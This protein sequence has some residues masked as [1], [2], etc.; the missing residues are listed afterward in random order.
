MRKLDKVLLIALLLG[1][2]FCLYGLHWGWVE[3]WNSDQMAFKNLFSKGK[4]PF[5][6]EDFQKPPFHTYFN[7]FLSVIPVKIIDKILNLSPHSVRTTQLLWSRTLTVFLFLGATI[8]VFYITKRFFG[9]FAARFI[10]IIFSTSAGF[11]ADS[12]Y[13]TADVP[14]LFWM[15]LAFYFTQNICLNTTLANYVYAGFFTGIATA[16]KYNALSI[17]IAIVV[18]H[19]LSVKD[20]SYIKMV[21]SKKLFLGLFMVLIGFLVGNPFALLNYSNFISDFRYNYIVTPIYN[22]ESTGVEQ[23]YWKFF[24]CFTEIIGW[25]S[26][27]VF[28]IGFL[29]SIYSLSRDRNKSWEKKG[30]ILLLSV[31]LVYYYKFG[32]FP[33][34]E[35]RFV[36]PILPFWLMLSGPLWNEVKHHKILVTGLLSILLSYNFVCDFYVGKRFAEDPRMEAQEW[37]K[38]NI[39]SNS[40][41]E[42]S[43]FVPSW[44]LLLGV[45]LKEEKMPFVSGRK[46]IYEDIF[47]PNSWV[48]KEASKREAEN[49]ETIEWYSLE[50]LMKRRPNYLAINSKYYGRFFDGQY[51]VHYPFMRKFFADLLNGQY[52]YEIVFDRASQPVPKIIYPQRIEFVDNEITI[53]KNKSI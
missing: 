29:F 47:L 51:A 19:L 53:L 28:M 8:L 40:S 44:N 48:I 18:A 36:M 11:I 13:L 52:P 34:L 46:R 33:R 31:F 20:D 5:Q 3:C 14:V 4:L 9:S 16:T 15:L 24:L 22:G 41:I 23:G 10:V 12:H 7:F 38:R 26:L 50:E 27:L 1:L 45:N 43:R 39:P 6:P 2:V 32:S 37:V 17:G 35:P 30:V 21:L 42:V 49:A 25:P